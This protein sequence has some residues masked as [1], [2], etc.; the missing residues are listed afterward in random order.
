M[1]VSEVTTRKSPSPRCARSLL[2]SQLMPRPFPVK[3]IDLLMVKI[4]FTKL[5]V[6]ALQDELEACIGIAAEDDADER[7]RA[8][9]SIQMKLESV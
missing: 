5:E 9:T 7:L 3:L 4:E 6:S 1:D 2:H 8:L